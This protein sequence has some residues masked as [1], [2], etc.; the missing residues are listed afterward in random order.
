MFSNPVIRTAKANIINEGKVLTSPSI[1]ERVGA[2]SNKSK[3]SMA[4]IIKTKNSEAFVAVLASFLS[5][6][7]RDSDTSFIDATGSPDATRA[8]QTE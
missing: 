3:K 8:Q 6:L 5:P 4:E 2:R 7:E 1:R